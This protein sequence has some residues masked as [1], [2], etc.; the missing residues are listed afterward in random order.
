[1]CICISFRFQYVFYCKMFLIFYFYIFVSNILIFFWGDCVDFLYL[2]L[3]LHFLA[4]LCLVASAVFD[5]LGRGLCHPMDH[6]PPGSSVHGGSPG[7]KTGVGCHAL[8]QGIFPTQGSNACL[9][10]C[11]S[12][13]YCLSL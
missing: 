11:R 7:K 13:L 10:H 9:P 4:V 12:I 8:L 6:S 1:M 3:V 5:S 2:S